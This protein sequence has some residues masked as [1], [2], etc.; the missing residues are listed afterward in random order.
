MKRI[1]NLTIIGIILLAAIYGIGFVVQKSWW[2]IVAGYI[3]YK[4]YQYFKL[5]EKEYQDCM[6]PS[7]GDPV[8]TALLDAVQLQKH[9]SRIEGVLH[10]SRK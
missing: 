9:R 10:G 8:L 7:A 6:N 2:I 3:I 5:K 4:I 1:I